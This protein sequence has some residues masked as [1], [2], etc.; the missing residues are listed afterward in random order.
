MCQKLNQQKIQL[1]NTFDTIRQRGYRQ[2]KDKVKNFD[3][4]NFVFFV[5]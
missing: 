1:R 2:Y 3:E 4:N 5:F